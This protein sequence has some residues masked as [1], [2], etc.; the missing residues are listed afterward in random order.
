VSPLDPD[1]DIE[2]CRGQR[3]LGFGTRNDFDLNQ[4]APRITDGACVK[5]THSHPVD[6][7]E[8]EWQRAG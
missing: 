5:H 4:R 1:S 7:D 8:E 6:E 3:D 2:P